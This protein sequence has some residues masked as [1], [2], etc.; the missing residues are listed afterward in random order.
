MALS[1]LADKRRDE[2]RHHGLDRSDGY[3]AA[4]AGVVAKFL[5]R[6]FDLEQD[7][8]G[9]IQER[10]ARLRQDGLPPKAVK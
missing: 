10:S 3:A 6:I 8:F 1:S 2:V 4:E 5:G 7:A 9:S